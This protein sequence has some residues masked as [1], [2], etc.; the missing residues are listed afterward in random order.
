LLSLHFSGEIGGLHVR[1]FASLLCVLAL[2]G[3]GGGASSGVAPPAGP[4]RPTGTLFVANAD[5]VNVFAAAASGNAVPQRQITGLY[6]LN[7][8]AL[9]GTGQGYWSEFLTAI[10][11]GATSGTVAALVVHVAHLQ[12]PG[13][14]VDEYGPAANGTNPPQNVQSPVPNVDIGLAPPF[15]MAAVPGGSGYDV[16]AGTYVE[17]T[18]PP[19]AFRNAAGQAAFTTG[20]RIALDSA[21]NVYVSTQNPGKI[22]VY[23]AGATGDATPI[24]TIATAAVP[25]PI[26][27]GPDG[28]LYVAESPATTGSPQPDLSNT[29]E[30]FAPGATSPA[31][32]LGPF[33]AD[34]SVVSIALDAQNELYVAEAQVVNRAATGTGTIAVFA[35]GASG[36]AAPVRI[37]QNPI[38]NMVSIAVG[39]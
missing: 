9:G 2:A 6:K 11:P 27:I 34:V 16:V 30:V 35:P 4:A 3:C 32:V 14:V 10:A 18:S 33:A 38:Q 23:A 28:T 13:F 39:P 12:Q 1:R 29:I 31:R 17:R 21:A 5:G 20:S 25:G 7:P 15:S 26:A 8:G 19:N 36:A 22:A 37:L 24:R